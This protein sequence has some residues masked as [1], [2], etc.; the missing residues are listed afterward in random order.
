MQLRSLDRDYLARVDA[1]WG[2]LLPLVA[3]FTAS[4]GGPVLLIQARPLAASRGCADVPQGLH[5]LQ[6]AGRTGCP[7]T[8]AAVGAA[9]ARQPY[10]AQA[11][12]PA[13]LHACSGRAGLVATDACAEVQ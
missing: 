1:W 4:R 12:G 9:Q 6:A 10:P 3:P 13:G 2:Q 11:P 5:Q 8:R 7:C